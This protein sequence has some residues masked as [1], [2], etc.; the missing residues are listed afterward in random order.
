MRSATTAALTVALSVVAPAAEPSRAQD[1]AQ[2]LTLSG[3]IISTHD[4]L[5]PAEVRGIIVERDFRIRIF[6]KN[7]IDEEWTATALSNANNHHLNLPPQ[8]GH[9]GRTLGEE[10]ATVVW[11]VAGPHSLQ[12]IS[13]GKQFAMV[14]NFDVDDKNRTCKLNA[15][16]ALEVG[17]KSVILRRADNGQLAEF[18]LDRVLSAACSVE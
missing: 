7:S 1:L 8:T 6:G 9:G 16:F 10:D 12:R 2:G 17:K 18:T 4:R 3:K 5:P 13:Q 15:K 11:R 14:L